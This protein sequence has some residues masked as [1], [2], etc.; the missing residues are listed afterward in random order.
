MAV[1]KLGNQLKNCS[2]LFL[3]SSPAFPAVVALSF[4][5][6]NWFLIA[7][8]LLVAQALLGSTGLRVGKKRKI[9]KITNFVWWLKLFTMAVLSSVLSYQCHAFVASVKKIACKEM[10]LYEVCVAR[11]GWDHVHLLLLCGL[12]LLDL[13]LIVFLMYV[14]KVSRSFE[15]AL[16]NDLIGLNAAWQNN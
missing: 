14:L 11:Q 6:L 16:V 10:N 15:R 7:L 5:T 13:F 9:K 3:V 4:F 1:K 12:P 8:G 2:F